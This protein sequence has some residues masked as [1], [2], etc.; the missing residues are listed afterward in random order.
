M[1]DPT[2]EMIVLKG[3]IKTSAVQSCLFNA[4]THKC[5]VIF[6]S[7]KRFTTQTEMWKGSLILQ[8]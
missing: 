4:A 2:K 5:E 3:E 7:G 6:S 8:R 1:F